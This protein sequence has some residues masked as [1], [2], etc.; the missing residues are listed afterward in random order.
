MM[1]G[2]RWQIGDHVVLLRSYIMFPLG[3][4]GAITHIYV[5]EPDL[6][7][8]RFESSTI[9]VPIFRHHLQIAT[10]SERY[11]SSQFIRNSTQLSPGAH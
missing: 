8:V 1:D 4:H 11:S 2:V 6:Y 9:E 3:A 5:T 10:L 7:R